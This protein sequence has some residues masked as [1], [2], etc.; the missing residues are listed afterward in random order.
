MLLSQLDIG[1]KNMRQL[2]YRPL[3]ACVNV[4]CSGAK[5]ATR[6]QQ[7]QGPPTIS[8]TQASRQKEVR[9]RGK[10]LP[11]A[12]ENTVSP[13]NLTNGRFVNWDMICM[14]LHARQPLCRT[15]S[16]KHVESQ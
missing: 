12:F 3:H 2:G 4:V 11:S 5:P 7:P 8:E 9:Q 15:F 6:G 16:A 13:A 10:A 14:G 1:R